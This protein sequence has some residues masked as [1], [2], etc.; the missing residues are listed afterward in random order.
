E[1]RNARLEALFVR[2]EAYDEQKK[3]D[4]PKNQAGAK[5]RTRV[6]NTTAPLI[7]QSAAPSGLPCDCY[8]PEWLEKLRNHNPDEYEELQVDPTPILD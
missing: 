7:S 4:S 3:K 6:R 2:L 8:D 5:P 1:W